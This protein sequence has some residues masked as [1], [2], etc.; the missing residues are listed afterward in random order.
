[1]RFCKPHS[2]SRRRYAQHCLGCASALQ[3]FYLNIK[4]V[5]INLLALKSENL[6]TAYLLLFGVFK[7]L[8]C[9]RM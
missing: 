4:T 5:L 2:S 7:L 1:M 3:F 6:K 8:L 9:K